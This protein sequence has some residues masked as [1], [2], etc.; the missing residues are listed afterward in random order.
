[1]LQR[2]MGSME[3]DRREYQELCDGANTL[4]VSW[5]QTG[6]F[7]FASCCWQCQPCQRRCCSSFMLL[8][9]DAC[10]RLLQA[11]RCGYPKEMQDAWCAHQHVSDGI[12]LPSSEME[13]WDTYMPACSRILTHVL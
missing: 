13:V 11:L 5:A 8:V 10:T 3:A 2:G 9:V 6:Q 12:L 7:C 1:M 4:C